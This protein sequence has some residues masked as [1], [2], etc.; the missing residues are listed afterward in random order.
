M[1]LLAFPPASSKMVMPLPSATPTF[2][3]KRPPG[4]AMPSLFRFF[5]VLIVLGAI[6]AAAMVYLATFVEPNTREMTVR[7]PPAKLGQ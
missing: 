5:I 2:G 4:D 6:G 3:S 7:I 1:R